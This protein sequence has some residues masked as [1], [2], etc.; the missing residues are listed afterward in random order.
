MLTGK[1]LIDLGYKPSKW[2]KEALAYA[3]KYGLSGENLI[4]YVETIRLHI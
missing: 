1:D 4:N 2:F 3:N